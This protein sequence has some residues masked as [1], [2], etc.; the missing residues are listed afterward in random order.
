M[1]NEPAV[2]SRPRNMS[3]TCAY[4]FFLCFIFSLTLEVPDE[5]WPSTPRPSS[6]EDKYGFISPSIVVFSWSG[7][8]QLVFS[9]FFSSSLLS[10]LLSPPFYFFAGRRKESVGSRPIPK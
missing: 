9:S 5:D 8:L 7:H 10:S 2:R 3:G 6:T 1:V 4:R